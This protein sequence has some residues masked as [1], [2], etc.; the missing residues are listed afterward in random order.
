MQLGLGPLASL[1]REVRDQ[2]YFDVCRGGNVMNRQSAPDDPRRLRAS[3]WRPS[4]HRRTDDIYK[5][6]RN[7]LIVFNQL[8]GEIAHTLYSTNRFMFKAQDRSSM[9][10]PFE[11]FYDQIPIGH[12]NLVTNVVRHNAIG[13]SRFWVWTYKRDP[14]RALLRV[15]TLRWLAVAMRYPHFSHQYLH[16]PIHGYEIQAPDRFSFTISVSA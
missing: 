7:L 4:S 3:W 16:E 5:P 2:I 1:P 13:G 6:C 15:P 12:R 10:K 11:L 14:A 8:S 9:A